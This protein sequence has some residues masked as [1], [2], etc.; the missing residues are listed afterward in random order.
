[1]GNEKSLSYFFYSYIVLNDLR[2]LLLPGGQ[3]NN[4]LEIRDKFFPKRS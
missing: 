2:V 1:M 3:K 4:N